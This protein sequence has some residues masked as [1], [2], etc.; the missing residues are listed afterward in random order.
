MKIGRI[1]ICLKIKQYELNVAENS[2]TL[3][4]QGRLENHLNLPS[5]SLLSSS[6]SSA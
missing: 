1:K 6:T 5:S 3:Y 4:I 2:Y